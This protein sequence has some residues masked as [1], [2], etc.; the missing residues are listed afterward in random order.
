MT[1]LLVLA[2]QETEVVFRLE[3]HLPQVADVFIEIDD[4]PAFLD[5][6]GASGLKAVGD[7]IWKLIVDL[8]AGDPIPDLKLDEWL[9]GVRGQLAVGVMMTLG[10]DPKPD[11]TITAD[12]RDREAA[13]RMVE[14][15]GGEE[16]EVAD[17]PGRELGEG[18]LF[19]AGAVGYYFSERLRARSILRRRAEG[20]RKPLAELES[21]VEARRTLSPGRGHAMLFVNF[22]KIKTFA[23]L[24]PPSNREARALIEKVGLETARAY[25]L[26]VDFE[27][28]S[29]VEKHLL[30]VTEKPTG[31]VGDAASLA[32]AAIDLKRHP[33]DSVHV[34]R[35]E[36]GFVRLVGDVADLTDNEKLKQVMT[37]FVEAGGPFEHALAGEPM[38]YSARTAAAEPLYRKLLEA[39]RG[40]GAPLEES[41]HAGLD[42]FV[43]DIPGEAR[44]YLGGLPIGA[45]AAGDG[46]FYSAGSLDAIDPSETATPLDLKTDA[47]LVATTDLKEIARVVEPFEALM[48]FETDPATADLVSGVLDILTAAGRGTDVARSVPGGVLLESRSKSGVTL[49]QAAFGGLAAA[50]IVPQVQ[51]ARASAVRERCMSNLSLL[52]KASW[53]WMIT[54]SPDGS[55][56]SRNTGAA[57]W[58]TLA[59]DGEIDEVPVCS[60]TGEKPRGP[61]SDANLLADDA[62]LAVCD[63]GETAI[64]VRKSGDV[65]EVRRG[66]DEYDAAIAGTK[67]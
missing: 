57:F 6:Y 55:S 52:V 12:F 29:V 22:D 15:F 13:Q 26:T 37:A 65:F 35:A 50:A 17:V 10:R 33:A 27:G 25:A 24:I 21:F 8:N 44:E 30:L 34:F 28:D 60:L 40:T 58:Q 53:N 46:V 54:R 61:A 5:R 62:P 43:V 42:A 23:A 32:N 63:H 19:A 18:G 49:L 56:F 16:I 66:T 48:G 38:V 4:V 47:W 11:V 2:L 41:K 45:F 1:L 59:D 31:L 64:V 36:A 39:I 51:K 3:R 20:A 9:R 14:A 67:P 7:A